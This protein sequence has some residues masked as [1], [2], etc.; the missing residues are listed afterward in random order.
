MSLPFHALLYVQNLAVYD[1]PAKNMVSFFYLV[2]LLHIAQLAQSPHVHVEK[3]HVRVV[4][5]E[6]LFNGDIP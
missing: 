3:S 2:Y 4:T 6:R 1:E 5:T